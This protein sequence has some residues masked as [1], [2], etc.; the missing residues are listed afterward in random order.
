ME[1]AAQTAEYVPLKG[2][3]EVRFVKRTRVR[4][5]CH[6]CGEPADYRHSFLLPNAR[7]N[8]A[9]SAYGRDDCSWCSDAEAF[10]CEEH[11]HSKHH[12]DDASLE[13]AGTFTLTTYPHMGLYW[14]E[15]LQPA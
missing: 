10:V 8:S 7:R 13:W 15:E 6:I 3:G 5:E 9:S 4:H 14:R 11:R 1:Q 12:P 2:E